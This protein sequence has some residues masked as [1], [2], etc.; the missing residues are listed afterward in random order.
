MRAIF[1]LVGTIYGCVIDGEKFPGRVE[2]ACL[3]G[4]SGYL[5]LCGPR[6]TDLL[7]DNE[8]RTTYTLHRE[9]DSAMVQK[10]AGK[11]KQ[12]SVQLGG[13]GGLGNTA[14]RIAQSWFARDVSLGSDQ[15]AGFVRSVCKEMRRLTSTTAEDDGPGSSAFQPGSMDELVRLF[16]YES[17]KSAVGLQT[18][19][20]GF[21]QSAIDFSYEV[22]SCMKSQP[23]CIRNRQTCLGRCN[24][25]GASVLTQDFATTFVKQELS[26]DA[27]GSNALAQGRAN[28][29]THSRVFDVPLFATGDAFALYSARLRVR[30]GLTCLLYT[31]PSPRDS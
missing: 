4:G 5:Q 14:D 25:A 18:C 15:A 17:C 26:V 31:S 19:Q 9:Y 27:V 22:S 2:G 12:L 30:G 1:I 20:V 6:G 24:G 3:T 23:D 13:A 11:F 21:A 29:T 16:L 28:C 7:S 10:Y 8:W